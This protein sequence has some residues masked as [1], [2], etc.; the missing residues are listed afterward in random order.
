MAASLVNTVVNYS[1]SL[2]L[3]FAGTVEVHVKNG[4]QTWEETLHGY[5]GALYMGT[6]LCGLGLTLSIVFVART[7]WDDRK[8]QDRVADPEKRERAWTPD[9]EN[10]R[11][12]DSSHS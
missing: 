1:I 4:G 6:G 7:Y 3:G 9:I 12:R 2:G 8:M 5:R 11:K 10:D